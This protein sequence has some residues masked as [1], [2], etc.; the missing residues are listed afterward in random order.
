M[1]G[2]TFPIRGQVKQNHTESSSKHRR[3][4]APHVLVAAK[5]MS[6]DK[7]WGAIF[8]HLDIVA[9][10]SVHLEL[11]LGLFSTVT[12]R[13]AARVQ[14][15]PRH[16]RHCDHRN[17]AHQVVHLMQRA[18]E[19]QATSM[20]AP[21]CRRPWRM[22]VMR[23]IGFEVGPVRPVECVGRETCSREGLAPVPFL[24]CRR[25]RVVELSG[26]QRPGDLVSTEDDAGRHCFRADELE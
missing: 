23:G 3:D 19:L 25:C 20:K 15:K 17:G 14:A 5:T 22:A 4:Q 8:E 13:I 12:A 18:I 24:V 21:R 26:L 16:D 11:P 6:K 1:R 7:S 10:Q 2:Q 9:L